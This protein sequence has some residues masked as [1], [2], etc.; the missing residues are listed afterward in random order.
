MCINRYNIDISFAD[1]QTLRDGRW[2]NDNIIDFYLNLV[3][4]RNSKVFI[5][6]THF[7]STLASRGYSG[8]ARWA[9]RKKIDLFTM[10]KV[11]VPVNISNTHWAL[12]VIDNLQKTITYYDS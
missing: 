9:K 11:I 6:T 2:L 12:A 8:V 4:K 1:L 7:Y 5:W 3:M 10:D